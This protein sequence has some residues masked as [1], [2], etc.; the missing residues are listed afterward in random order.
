LPQPAPREELLPAKKVESYQPLME[1]EARIVNE[2]E[3][4]V[5]L[6]E[7][8][9]FD[10]TVENT[11]LS[12]F[13]MGL[14]VDTKYNIVVHPGVAGDVYLDLKKVTLADVL[15][16]LRDM[17]DLHYSVAGNLIQVMPDSM[18]TR[19][20]NMDYVS[21]VRQG[22]SEMR[23]STGSIRDAGTSSG[24]DSNGNDKNKTS[25]SQSVETA[26]SRVRTQSSVDVWSNLQQAIQALIGSGE[27][28]KVIVMEQAGVIVV[29]ALLSELAIVEEFL[30]RSEDSLTRQVIL[31]AKI[32]EVVL[33][34]QYERGI[35]WTGLG[36]VGGEKGGSYLVNLSSGTVQNSNGL[37]GVFTSA[38]S[39][40]DFE[41]IVQLLETQ[42]K[43]RVLSSP[44]IATVNNQKAVIKVGTDEFFVTEVSTT[45]TTGTAT[46]TTPSVTLTPFFSG[47]ALDVTPQISRNGD[48]IL[49]IH[50]T[51]SEVTDQTKLVT[52]G[53]DTLSL[54]LALS[55]IRESDSIV[56]A[57]NGQIVVIGGLMKNL[58]RD[59]TAGIPLIGKLPFIGKAFSQ[60]KKEFQRSELVIL[61][62]PIVGESAEYQG[63][64]LDSLRR[65]DAYGEE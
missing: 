26:G 37:E 35:D 24:G 17:F 52:L 16:V 41:G 42:G 18:E 56:K 45:T 40:V 15:G 60:E 43:V 65:L 34:S 7:N 39:L 19:V 61:V 51:V 63:D 55:T 5:V 25:S 23:V 53:S 46:T 20:L 49:H 3:Q 50:P 54:P 14:C 29:R 30:D 6:T 57:K 13:L 38:L 27:G 36:E 11:P 32:L 59:R 9:T 58:S 48:V 62:R 47:I 10:V 8:A 44:R 64:V 1:P 22:V 28:R 21:L 31:E 2:P 4:K 33:D 12:I